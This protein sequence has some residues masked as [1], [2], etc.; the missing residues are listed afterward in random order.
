MRITLTIADVV[1]AEVEYQDLGAGK[2]VIFFSHP[3]DFT[4]VCTSEF[5]TFASMQK[6]FAS[7]NTELAQRCVCR[8]VPDDDPC[9]FGCQDDAEGTEAAAAQP[10]MAGPVRSDLC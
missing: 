9:D 2:W 5:M 4:P 3:A 10:A 8:E 6:E 1:G 7:Y